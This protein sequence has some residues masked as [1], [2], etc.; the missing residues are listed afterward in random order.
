MGADAKGQWEEAKDKGPRG[1]GKGTKGQCC[2]DKGPWE[3]MQWGKG[4]RA[5]ATGQGQGGKS[6]GVA[7]QTIAA[8]SIP[9]IV[10]IVR[11]QPPVSI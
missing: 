4:D 11:S 2:K 3:Q 10:T 8:V 5:R 9:S 1:K 6:K 7:A